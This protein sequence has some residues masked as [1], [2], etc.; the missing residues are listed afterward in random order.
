M[1]KTALTVIS[2][3]L[4]VILLFIAPGKTDV[5]E[6]HYAPDRKVDIQHI[7]ID[8][9][10]DFGEQTVAGITTIEFSPIAMPLDELKL[11]AVRLD[12]SSVTSTS[13][14]GDYTVTDE[15]ITITFD[16]PVAPGTKTGVTIHYEAEPVKGLYF[17]TP[18]M[19]YPE[20]EIHIWTQGEAHEAPHWFPNYDYPNERST[21]EMICHVPPEMTV[22]SN[23][24]LVSEDI[25]PDTGLKAVRWLQDKPLVNYLIALV[26]GNFKKIESTYKNI[27]LAFYTTPP[28][29]DLAQNSF[30]N[31]EDMMGFLEKETGVPYPWDQYNQVTIKDFHF[32]GMENT[33]LTVLTERTLFPDET[34]TI[35]SSQGLVVH[36]LTHQWFGDYITCKDWSH[37][38]LN[39]GFGTF[40]TH[41]YN[42][43][44]DGH[45]SMLYGLYR[46]TKRVLAEREIHKP[47][48]YREY[49]Y[50]MEQFDYRNYPK[51]SWILHMLRTKLGE[52]LFRQCVNT[53]AERYALSSV[54]TEDFNS[55]LEEMTGRSFDRFFDQWVYH[56]RHP[57]LNVEYSWS[58]KVKL[59]KVTVKQTHEV[60]EKIPLFHFSTK[61]RFYFDDRWADRDI[62]V[63]NKEHDF[64]FPFETKPSVVRFDPQYGLLADIT[65]SKPKD[66]LY[67]QLALDRDVIGRIRAILDLSEKKD[68]KTVEKLTERLNND[69]FYGVRA[70][71]AQALREIH[72]SE[73]F[74]ALTG[75]LEQPD[76]RVRQKVV[77]AVGGFY[78]PETL[79]I[80]KK[81]IKSEKNPDIKASALRSLGRYHSK[82]TKKILAG[83]LQSSSFR[84]VLADAA[85]SAIRMLDDSSYIQQLKKT[86]EKNETA[87][88]SGSF[89]QALGTLAHIARNED[90]RS[91]ERKF[92][93]AYV[94]HPKRGIREQAIRALGTLGDPAAISVVETFSGDDR[95]DRLQRAAKDALKSLR[96]KKDVVPE[97]IISLRETVDELRKENEELSKDVEDI[98]KRLDA[99]EENEDEED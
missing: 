17:R 78:R 82:D 43:Y 30:R 13:S 96:E 51:G 52:D 28:N 1:R 62:A 90:D 71:A 54:V 38:W 60:N 67:A 44:K 29:I 99:Q 33:T 23:G 20:D 56:G 63:E 39:E 4:P 40:Y 26:A 79:E 25:D 9:T 34:E 81:V 53:Y 2:T 37:L 46:D 8:V 27:P 7:I 58:E 92:L 64:Y 18:D 80:M 14:I 50:A 68:K 91:A 12:V 48:V 24:R 76:A 19:G 45:D 69:P 87:F 57:D 83:F 59:A 95:D 31:T 35:R 75:S 36:E 65:F 66:M 88:T 41:L 10:P 6:R 86:L 70:E 94:N 61:I 5:A 74:D 97:E 72:T 49:E 98:K 3:I 22:L 55:V 47:M 16:P 11:D 32:G 21:S 77:Q 15:D 85:V 42:G 93:A 89:G 84:N 73:A